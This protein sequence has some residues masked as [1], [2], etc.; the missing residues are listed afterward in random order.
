M[1]DDP[2]F[3]FMVFLLIEGILIP[4]I[5]NIEAFTDVIDVQFAINPGF[6]SCHVDYIC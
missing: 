4:L 1:P 3:D 5:E 6:L 2:R